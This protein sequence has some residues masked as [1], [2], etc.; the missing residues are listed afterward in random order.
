MEAYSQDV[1]LSEN[2]IWKSR[3]TN[4]TFVPGVNIQWVRNDS[5]SSSEFNLAPIST[6]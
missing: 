5:V 4:L 3:K 2:Q 6:K 1:S